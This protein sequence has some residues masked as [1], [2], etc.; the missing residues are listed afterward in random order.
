ML[1]V[2]LTKAQNLSVTKIFSNFYQKDKEKKQKGTIDKIQKLYLLGSGI[3]LV[4]YLLN[5][6]TGSLSQQR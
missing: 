3:Q 2:I 1:P 5:I 4:L 6:M